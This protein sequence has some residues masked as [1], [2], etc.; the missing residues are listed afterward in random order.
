MGMGRMP[1]RGRDFDGKGVK[2]SG[3]GGGRVGRVTAWCL[4]VCLSVVYFRSFFF[5]CCPFLRYECFACAI[6]MYV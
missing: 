1:S 5:F 6:R 4:S 3:F 2:R